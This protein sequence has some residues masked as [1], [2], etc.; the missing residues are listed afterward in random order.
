MIS[1]DQFVKV[2][3]RAILRS[4]GSTP[5]D[6]AGM[7]ADAIEDVLQ[8]LQELGLEQPPQRKVESPEP[9]APAWPPVNPEAVEEPLVQLASSIPDRVERVKNPDQE[10]PPPLRRIDRP[11]LTVDKLNLLIQ[12]RT[13]MEIT[14]DVPNLN[15]TTFPATLKRNVLSAHGEEC[16]K[17]IYYEPR[18]PNDLSVEESLHVSEVPFDLPAILVKLKSQAAQLLRPRDGPIVSR[19]P[20]IGGVV[21][22]GERVDEMGTSINQIVQAWTKP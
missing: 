2:A 16:V 11:R 22:G 10:S 9:A 8:N 1:R 3:A 20:Q 15:G 17:L 12:E 19:A 18:S 13:P 5:E 14:I 21:A 4:Q 6:Q 7:V